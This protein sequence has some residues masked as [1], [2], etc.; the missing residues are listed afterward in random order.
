MGKFQEIKG[1]VRAYFDALEKCT[2]QQAEQVLG[3]Y[4]SENYTWEG[5]YPFLDKEGVAD[6]AE[7]FWK[8]LKQ[9]L[10]HM[11]R[12]QDL[13]MAGTATDGKTWV[14]S[15]G[16][17]MGLFE[18]DYLGV[19]STGKIQHLQYAEY[20]CVENGKITHTAMFVDLLGFM[21]EAGS[22][23]LPPSTGHYFVYPGP[24]DH[25]GLMFEDAPKEKAAKSFH[26][27]QSMIDDLL[28]LFDESQDRKKTAEIFR[29]TWADD[30]TW[31][32]P[33]GIGASY[34]IA[35]YQEQHSGP[36]SDGLKDLKV[37][38]LKSYFA[39]GDFVCFYASMGATPKGGFLGLPGGGG[40]AHMRGDIDIYYCK[41]G[42]ILE[43]W[44]FIDLPFWLKQQG[45]DI[46]ERTAGILNPKGELQQLGS[47]P[48]AAGYPAGNSMADGA[49]SR[50]TVDVTIHQGLVNEQRVA[51]LAPETTVIRL[52]K[53]AVITA[54]A[55]DK[56]RAMGIT[57]KR[58]K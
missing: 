6:V 23:P 9:S 42:K 38:E 29:K 56:A 4:M 50:A 44:C 45:L 31:Y 39:E 57:I 24:R 18:K 3:Q 26:I 51:S 33:S 35:G 48:L 37:H 8:P 12:R 20:T 27:V 52:G 41:D 10:S 58:V 34:T 15:M 1:L 19:M 14:M 55:R 25:N 2:P 17:F 21:Q 43:N 49:A 22:Y 47:N 16:Q 53:G 5:V 28:E 32:G 40:S 46:F 11:Q 36:F 13:F 30:M 7:V 54:L